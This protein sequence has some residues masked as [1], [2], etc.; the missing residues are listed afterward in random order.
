MI[1]SP[2][3]ERAGHKFRVSLYHYTFVGGFIVRN[4]KY[5]LTT[6]PEVGAGGFTTA[7]ALFVQHDGERASSAVEKCLRQVSLSY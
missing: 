1:Y 4:M 2:A 5:H 7:L 3:G 6:G